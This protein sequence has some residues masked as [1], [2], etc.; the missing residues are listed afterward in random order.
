MREASI[1]IVLMTSLIVMCSV[2]GFAVMAD[3]YDLTSGP[4]ASVY[5][6]LVMPR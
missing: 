6:L 5:D 4:K 1:I 2:S 3:D